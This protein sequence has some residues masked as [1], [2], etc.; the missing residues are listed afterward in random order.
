MLRGYW[1]AYRTR[2]VFAGNPTFGDRFDR[3]R[4]TTLAQFASRV[5][6]PLVIDGIQRGDVEAIGA[7]NG[8]TDRVALNALA[9]VAARGDLRAVELTL[10]LASL[11]GDPNN[12]DVIR[13]AARRAIG[14]DLPA[15]LPSPRQSA[16]ILTFPS[17]R[18]SGRKPARD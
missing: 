11:A 17:E 18:P 6:G 9:Y 13:D 16:A 14:D 8:V 5:G 3:E 4:A 12:G 10:Q 1:D 2:F 7:A 15:R